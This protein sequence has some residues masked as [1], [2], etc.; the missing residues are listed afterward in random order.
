MRR[1]ILTGAPG[2]GKTSLLRH[3]EDRGFFVVEEAATDIIASEQS[4]GIQRPWDNPSFM[5]MVLDLQIQRQLSAK[6]SLSEIQF[7]DRSPLDTYALCCYSNYPISAQLLKK[8]KNAQEAGSYEKEVL[9]IDNLGYIEP[10]EARKISFED[11]L[12]FEKI[13]EEVYGEWGYNCIKIPRQSISE[14]VQTILSYVAPEL[15]I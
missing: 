7:F 12:H 3:L 13:H 9:F 1:F 6:T 15:K 4:K 14:R 10:T 11:A 5:E 2:A 8:I